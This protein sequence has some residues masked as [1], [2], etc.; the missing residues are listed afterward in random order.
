[1]DKTDKI[2]SDAVHDI[3]QA[4]VQAPQKIT[5][6]RCAYTWFTKTKLINVTCPNCGIKVSKSKGD[7][8]DAGNKN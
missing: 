3:T 5:C 6:H 2:F 1:M 8:Q 4:D 7:S